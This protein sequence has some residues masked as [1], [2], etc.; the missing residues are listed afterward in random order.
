MRIQLNIAQVTAVIDKLESTALDLGSG[1]AKDPGVVD[2]ESGSKLE[3]IVN[4]KILLAEA[5]VVLKTAVQ[6]ELQ[7]TQLRL[8][9]MIKEL[10]DHGY[11]EVTAELTKVKQAVETQNTKT[12]DKY[13]DENGT[14]KEVLK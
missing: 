10:N 9:S 6:E 5:I 7:S 13:F 1:L 14:I 11:T 2:L 4:P 3:E 8:D 12:Q